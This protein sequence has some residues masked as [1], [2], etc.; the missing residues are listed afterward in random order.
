[1]IRT[2]VWKEFRE[3]RIPAV[4]LLV[5]AV[6][7]VTAVVPAFFGDQS[8]MLQVG[9][10][11][12]FSGACG[13][14]TGAILL[15]NED[16]SGTQTLLDMQPTPRRNIWFIKFGFGAILT[17][18]QSMLLLATCLPFFPAS[19]LTI[20]T[21]SLHIPTFVLAGGFGLGCGLLGSAIAKHVLGAIGYAI[22]SLHAISMGFGLLAMILQGVIYQVNPAYG[23]PD[24]PKAFIPL[25]VLF[26]PLPTVLSALVY[27]RHDISR[28]RAVRRPSESKSRPNLRGLGIRSIL[29]LSARRSRVGLV[30]GS[31]VALVFGQVMLIE[32]LILWPV[33]TLVIGLVQG[34]FTFAD[35]QLFGSFRMLAE[36]RLPLGRFWIVKVL[37]RFGMAI[38]FCF[39]MLLST[40]FF[41]SHAESVFAD[42][43]NH[44]FRH[45]FEERFGFDGLMLR[46]IGLRVYLTLWVVY[47]FCFGQIAGLLFRRT[48]VAL[49]LGLGASLITVSVWVPSLL[50]GGIPVWQMY[51]IPVGL[52]ILARILVWRWATSQ[53][54]AGRSIA[55]IA[56]ASFAGIAWITGF[57]VWRMTDTPTG[58]DR[59]QENVYLAS[60][61]P[62]EHDASRSA[63]F[64]VQRDVYSISRTFADV[65]HNSNSRNQ[66]QDQVEGTLVVG[67]PKNSADLDANLEHWMQGDWLSELRQAA[68][69]SDA[70]FEDP[71]LA[72]LPYVA[73]STH[74][75]RQVAA[76][77]S[78]RALQQQARGS[79][80]ESLDLLLDLLAVSRHVQNRSRFFKAHTGFQMEMLACRALAVWA[81]HPGLD[82]KFLGRALGAMQMHERLR[83]GTRDNVRSEYVQSHYLLQHPAMMF[84][85]Y[86]TFKDQNRH[87]TIRWHEG[88]MAASIIAPWEKRRRERLLNLAYEA[89]FDA[90]ET[91]YQTMQS[92][93]NAVRSWRIVLETQTNIHIQS[94]PPMRDPA[95]EPEL[96]QCLLQLNQDLFL[97]HAITYIG[98]FEAYRF[99]SQ[100]HVRSTQIQLALMA[101][102]HMNGQPAKKLE[103]LTPG[104]LPSIPVDPY[105]SQPFQYRLSAGENIRWFTSSQ[106]EDLSGEWAADVQ[107]GPAGAAVAPADVGDIP[108]APP[109]GDAPSQVV[110]DVGRFRKIEPKSGVLWS[111]GPDGRNGGGTAQDTRQF[112]EMNYWRVPGGN[113]DVIFIIPNT[114]PPK[115]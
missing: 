83:P 43:Q 24:F 65:Q 45:A 17:A 114:A 109:P 14:V 112:F 67:W 40:A 70:M 9:M 54:G 7:C 69:Q 31:V 107:T 13:L 30:V 79:H 3:Q 46:S 73:D 6:I 78:M 104:L 50:S 44:L 56:M 52:L 93:A 85:Q 34:S 90:Q 72:S 80:A 55:I 10:A 63:L 102:Q 61:P 1:M 98:T 27:C 15:A 101:Y 33:F 87:D 81:R 47:G 35:E 64:H 18:A 37:W 5:L 12:V 71:R 38:W 84:H 36:Q 97:R 42:H 51:A 66:F 76:V 19:D 32:P 99:A 68:K 29:W 25:F 58:T 16:E 60:L 113:A 86:S 92:R 4:V 11:A 23:D 22:I 105:S 48:I 75:F 74:V 49:F 96:E 20:K 39:L 77:V 62:V 94:V 89:M 8:L 57:I 59:I 100:M 26:V 53:I 110:L 115:K 2:L 106:L 82:A 95:R 41:V 108:A 91:D 103:Q 88:L 28:R 21:L 111:V